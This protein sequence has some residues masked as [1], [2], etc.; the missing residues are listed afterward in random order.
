MGNAASNRRR[1]SNVTQSGRKYSADVANDSNRK[2]V[3][4]RQ[5]TVDLSLS[6]APNSKAEIRKRTA[7]FVLPIDK[8]IKVFCN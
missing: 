2:A 6:L 3:L 4:N 7:S 8:I 5:Q 1:E